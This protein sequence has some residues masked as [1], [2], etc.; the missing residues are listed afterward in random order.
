MPRLN[1]TD[2][3]I[4]SFLV[5]EISAAEKQELMQWVAASKSNAEYFDKKKEI[6]LSSMT[7]AEKE[8]FQPEMGYRRFSSRRLVSDIKPAARKSHRTRRL[9]WGACAAACLA[10]LFCLRF[11]LTPSTPAIPSETSIQVPE[12][13]TSSFTLPDGTSVILN[14]GSRLSYLS[15]FGST[16]RDVRLDGEAYFDVI[17]NE[18]LPFR[19]NTDRLIVT[20]LGT[21]FNLRNYSS[22]ADA[23]IALVQ[24][25]VEFSHGAQE[26]STPMNPGEIAVLDKETGLSS[27]AEGRLENVV[28][29]ISGHITFDDESLDSIVRK[30]ERSYNVS[31]SI[32]RPELGAIR[33]N[34]SFD[35][36]STTV[37]EILTAL[38]ATGKISFK[39]QNNTIY[40]IQ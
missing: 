37:A 17:H 5:G 11:A 23:Q 19:V 26:C 15:D 40:Y 2:D 35:K 6:W 21:A 30:L 33:F 10:L 38:S 18:E 3:L 4:S 1:K 28:C 20:D 31:I 25:K 9:V 12:G 24:G 8:T 39:A 7:S 16:H 36:S 14:S 34:G 27:V 13:S 22:D 29:W 32:E